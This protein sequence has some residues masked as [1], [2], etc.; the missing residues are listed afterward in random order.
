MKT[1][2]ETLARIEKKY[3]EAFKALPKGWRFLNI[4]EKLLKDDRVWSW[5]EGP[6]GAPENPWG[7]S[8]K[9][10][11]DHHPIIRRVSSENTANDAKSCLEE[12]LKKI[13]EL[14]RENAA[15][16]ERLAK[17]HKESVS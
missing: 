15:L 3:P 6:F 7:K 11:E 8:E 17:I 14:E 4:G 9:V 10:D 2:P 12:V 16:K 5:G 1:T 13:Q